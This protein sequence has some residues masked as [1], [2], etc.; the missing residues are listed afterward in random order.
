MGFRGSRVQISASRPIYPRIFKDLAQMPSASRKGLGH[1]WDIRL[2][3]LPLDLV[4]CQE[5]KPVRHRTPGSGRSLLDAGFLLRA[6]NRA[7]V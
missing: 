3:I 2:L 5:S 6:H 7:F 1:S 4:L